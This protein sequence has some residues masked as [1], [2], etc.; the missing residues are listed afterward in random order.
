[1]APA[2]EASGRVTG[3]VTAAGLAAGFGRAAVCLLAAALLSACA[4]R[5]THF[6]VDR[7]P[8]IQQGVTTQEDVRRWFGEPNT[9]RSRGSGI[10]A[11]VYTYEE[12]KTRDT[13]TL[14]RIGQ[15]IAMLFGQRVITP[16]M[17]VAYEQTT[18]HELLVF[19]DR[20]GIVSEYEYTR[21]QLPSRRVS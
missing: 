15:W 20:E 11:W 13:R 7:V 2:N 1:M 8:M 14:V 10:S 5:G 12:T 18:E 19:F 4:T 16:P 6:D 21:R 9:I 17:G 3:S